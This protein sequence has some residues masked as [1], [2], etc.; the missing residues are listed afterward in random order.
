M[1]YSGEMGKGGKSPVELK[2]SL[3]SDQVAKVLFVVSEGLIESVD[4]V[5]LDTTE[6]ASFDAEYDWRDG[7]GSQS[8]ITFSDGDGFIASESTLPGFAGKLIDHGSGT[9]ETFA[10]A[11]D[12]IETIPFESACDV[13]RLTFNIPVM[14]YLDPDGNLVGAAVEI[15]IYTRPTTSSTWT[16]Y[17]NPIKKGKTTNGY[18]FDILVPRPSGASSA[19]PWQINIKRKTKDSTTTKRQ[20]AVN[21]SMITQIYKDSTKTYPNTALVGVKIND[22]TQFGNRVPEVMFRLKGKKVTIPSN[23]NAATKTYTG[24]WDGTFNTLTK[25]YTNNPAWILLDVLTDTRAGLGIDI[26]DIDKY[27][28]YNLAKYCDETFSI[29]LDGVTTNYYRYTCDY[30][31]QERQGVTQFIAQIL[32][33]CNANVIT[34]EFGQISVVYIYPNQPVKRNVT[35]ANV[36]DGSFTYQSSGLEQRTTLVNVTYNNGSNFGRTDTTTISDDTLIDRYGLQVMDVVLPG[37]YYEAQAIRKARYTLYT[38]CNFVNFVSFSVFLEG[39]TY[40]IGDLIRVFDNYNQNETQGG[41][42]ASIVNA[43]GNTT[44][45]FD[46]PCVLDAGSYTFYIY[47]T[48][49]NEHTKSVTGGS[50]ISQIVFNSTILIDTGAPFVFSGPAAGKVYRVTDIQKSEESIYSVSALEW[51]ES[52][53]DYIEDGIVI[54]SKSGD[55]ANINDLSTIPVTNLEVTQNFGTNGAYKTARLVVSWLWDLVET[56]KYKAKFKLSYSRDGNQQTVIENINS[57][58][59][60]I[61]NPVPGSYK[62]TVWAVNPVTNF[63]SQPVSVDYD[64]RLIDATS[65]LSHPVSLYVTGTSGTSF[66]TRDLSI[67]WLSNSL[68]ATAEDAL[69]DF[70]VEVKDPV[71]HA[72]KKIYSV[73]PSRSVLTTDPL[74]PDTQY[75]QYPGDFV[76]TYAENHELFGSASRSVMF[77]VYAR[78][79]MNDLSYSVDATFTNSSP[80]FTSLSVE[81]SNNSVIVTVTASTDVD[82]KDY[83][84]YRGTSSGFTPNASNLIYRGASN[85][86][87]IATPDNS[88]YYYKAAISDSFGEDSL[89]Y[90]SAVSQASTTVTNGINGA[91]VFKI[92]YKATNQS[93]PPS[94]PSATTNGA[95]PAGWS[96]SPVTLTGVEAQFESDGSQ[97]A[98]ST[99]TTWSTPYLSY[100]K[101]NKL[102]AIVVNTGALTVDDKLTIGTG[103]KIA[104]GQTAY[105]TGTGYWLEYNAGNPRFSL[106][107]SGLNAKGIAWD[108]SNFYVRGNVIA[109]DNIQTGAVDTLQVAQN[110]IT[111]LYSHADADIVWTTTSPAI[112][113][114][115]CSISSVNVPANSSGVLLTY[116]YQYYNYAG[117]AKNISYYF[118]RDGQMITGLGVSPI[119]THTGASA[120]VN[121]ASITFF[122]S[123]A[124]AGN[125]SYEIKVCFSWDTSTNGG[126]VS[127]QLLTAVAFSR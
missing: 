98:G 66:A 96:A 93:S 119:K 4:N 87:V 94:T 48:D 17:A 82:V 111:K 28:I 7:A 92:Y 106:G 16:L 50:T 51:S 1:T 71:T 74:D 37:C 69:N 63:I 44:I 45:T 80:A 56:Q 53:F 103:G 18:T 79:T 25:Y 75:R 97:P 40:K 110:A 108:G 42:A 70:V 113:S 10:D 38:N 36:I 124:T 55:Y 59:F 46:R 14:S 54:D 6:I 105:D 29:T 23:Y 83:L 114:T 61:P 81:S 112:D 116:N 86:V 52:I 26:A 118:S 12:H 27:S 33:I 102:E 22:P 122:D 125:H 64:F 49:G 90:S 117:A 62:I 24:V 2:D 101:V 88:T 47:D 84:V 43:G 99:T 77:S 107:V 68:D 115:I 121:P 104:S 123:G 11:I 19:S 126:R 8:I 13:V 67:S 100:F 21:L 31:F 3:V 65:T 109:T 34:N 32:S 20:N 15:G 72:I 9:V 58:T 60:D 120:S 85:K 5:Y 78:D 41:L 30:Q 39:L 95:T 89:N 76:F 127:S 91:Q 35:N 73:T 57:D